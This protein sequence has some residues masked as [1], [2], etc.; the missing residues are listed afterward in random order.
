MKRTEVKR[1]AGFAGGISSLAAALV[2]AASPASAQ[3]VVVFGDSLSD[4]GNVAALAGPFSPQGR[5]SNGTN[6][7]DQLYGTVPAPGSAAFAA[8][9]VSHVG[10]N[11]LPGNVLDYA[12]GGAFTGTGNLS[13][14]LGGP[15]NGIGVSTEVGVFLGLG[16]HLNPNDTV[17]MWAG[18]NNGFYALAVAGAGPPAN[19]QATIA[20]G[21]FSAVSSEIANLQTLIGAGAKKLVVL[22]LPDLG[23]TP[24]VTAQGAAGQQGGALYSATFNAALS[25]GLGTLASAA[26][27]TNI[28]QA[29]IAALFRLVIANPAAYGFNPALVTSAC[30]NGAPF[31]ASCPGY[32]FADGVHP[33]QL[34]YGYIAEYVGL[35]TNAAPALQQVSR[36]G[37]SGIYSNELITNAV[38]D[39]LSGFISGAYVA[40]NGPY[41]EFL[42]SYS[43]YDG[44]GSAPGLSQSVGGFRAGIDKKSGASLTGASVSYI[45]GTQSSG[46][47][48]NDIGSWRADVYGTANFGNAYLSADAG[49]SS[50]SLDGI[51]RDT[52]FPGVIANGTTSGYVATASAEA[53][54]VAQMGGFAVIPSGRVT[55]YHSQVNAYDETAP[56]LAMH[57][58]DRT[59][60]AV[61]LGGKVRLA[62]NVPGIGMAAVG[63]GEVGYE[64]FVSSSSSALKSTFVGNTALPTIVS[65]GDVLSPGILGKVG[66]STQISAN[67]FVD[68]QYGISI[69][70]EGGQTHTG[71][72]RIKATY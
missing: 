30:S 23:S 70:D 5:F 62:A 7:V 72:L 48:K 59:I 47:V 36:L 9:Y 68:F 21:A 58:D 10:P 24:S 11:S 15:V 4:T 28:I 19:A 61:S 41:V 33:T 65:A 17:T 69:H 44:K 57:F 34:A 16:G 67:A 27:G 12:V 46:A 26:P 22:N 32:I 60:D 20:N 42:G 31:V 56:I 43:N 14:L 71:D 18:A 2:L 64:S 54:Y 37:E 35:L 52:G 66:L 38:F 55:Y 13:P 50:L 25:S 40:K 6:W 29:D 45:D 3:R 1:T 53:G 63:F 39:R 49:I 8:G 51:K